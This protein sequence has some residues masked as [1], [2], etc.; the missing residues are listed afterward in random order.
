MGVGWSVVDD[1]TG[2]EVASDML[3]VEAEEYVDSWDN[4]S[5]RIVPAAEVKR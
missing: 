3:Y 2:E 4:G 1:D 5:L